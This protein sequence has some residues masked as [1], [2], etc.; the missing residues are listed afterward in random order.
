MA[1]DKCKATHKFVDWLYWITV[2]GKQSMVVYTNKM[3][4]FQLYKGHLLFRI[5]SEADDKIFKLNIKYFQT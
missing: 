2:N 4:E 3:V 5:K 1:W